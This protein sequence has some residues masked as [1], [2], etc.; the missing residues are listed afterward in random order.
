M[1]ILSIVASPRGA[2]GNTAALAELV[3]DGARDK[4]AETET[5]FLPGSTVLPCQACDVCHKK[6][7]CPQKDDFEGIK[8]KV[9]E[10]D[11]LILGSPNYI[12]S[13]SAQMKAF[14]DRCCGVIHCMSF[15]GRYG[16][17]V[18][19]SGGGDEQPICDYLNHFL[20]MTGITPVGSVWATMGASVGEGFPQEK[21]DEARR[22][23]AELVQAIEEKAVFP[24]F[25]KTKDEFKQ[26]M[27]MLMLYRKEDW[28]YE[29]EYWQKHHGPK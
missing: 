19:T 17:S 29:W 18:V 26:R 25:E 4:G 14:M 13:V 28:P 1:R 16:V 11:A 5:V 9:Y 3:L 24:D 6:G 23:G 7:V 2:K 8:Q 10:S 20:M 27:Q 21:K 15:E 22:V 12:W